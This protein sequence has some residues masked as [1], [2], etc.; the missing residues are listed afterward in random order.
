MSVIYHLASRH[1]WQTACAM[2]AYI[3][4]PPDAHEHMLCADAA[5]YHE[6]ANRIYSDHDDLLLLFIDRL[7]LG[8]QQTLTPIRVAGLD[9]ALLAGP[10][11]LEVVFET[12]NYRPDA[13]GRFRQHHETAALAQHGDESLTDICERALR[14]LA[15]FERPWWVAGGW[16]ID[17]FIGTR[18]R[19]HADLEIA[20][21][22]SDHPALYDHLRGWDLR[23]V[24]PGA[25]FIP[26]DGQPLS[27]PYHQIWARQGGSSATTPD[28]FSADPSM[29]DMLIEDHVG[30]LW[31][32]RRDT[33]ITRPLSAFGTLRH[34]VPCVQ[35]EIALLFKAK[36]PRFKD[37][38]D[39]E[40]AA[41]L[42]DA[43]AR[44]WLRQALT[45]LQPTHAWGDSL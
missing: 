29:L 44:T 16:A 10:L 20:I 25:A 4:D 11:P 41:P 42:L 5:T 2:G 13:S 24:A 33:S 6:L 12:A 15:T 35:P 43:S 40:R 31:R 38:R 19:P 23:I 14:A 45:A 7:R 36:A 27:S 21:M 34:G 30:E 37:Q 32:Y 26:W 8:P 22:A 28:E 39:F 18:T 1:A 3:A 9:V 17:L